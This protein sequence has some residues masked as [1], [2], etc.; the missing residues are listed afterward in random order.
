MNPVGI[1][2]YID[3]NKFNLGV[4]STVYEQRERPAAARAGSCC[5]GAVRLLAL[6]TTR[7]PVVPCTN[8]V[9]V[10]PVIVNVYRQFSQYYNQ[11]NQV[12]RGLN[13]S[14]FFALVLR[15]AYS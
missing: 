9:V 5:A 6:Y 13:T 3:Q 1:P 2:F 4:I 10:V 11:V 14:R 8:H 15:T 7:T 12:P